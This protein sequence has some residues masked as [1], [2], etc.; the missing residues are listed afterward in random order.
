MYKLTLNCVRCVTE[1][2]PPD[3]YVAVGKALVLNCTLTP[4]YT[5]ALGA[6]SMYFGRMSG[7]TVRI[8]AQ[9]QHVINPRILQL[10]HPRMKIENEG[11]YACYMNE[12]SIGGNEATLLGIPAQVQ[13]DCEYISSLMLLSRLHFPGC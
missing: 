4:H 5:K 7:V 10:R 9:F 2:T 3:A 1:I 12:S 13:V 6:S 8:P 11:P